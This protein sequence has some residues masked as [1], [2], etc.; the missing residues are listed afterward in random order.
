MI[1]EISVWCAIKTPSASLRRVLSG[2][3]LLLYRE[4]FIKGY[5]VGTE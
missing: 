3:S 2:F 1:E 5:F 4:L